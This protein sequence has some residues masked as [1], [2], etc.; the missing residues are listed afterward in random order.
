[1]LRKAETND[2][3]VYGD[4]KPKY[5]VEVFSTDRITSAGRRLTASSS[6]TTHPLSRYSLV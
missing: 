4:S 5:Q 3:M 1:M 6:E 2:W